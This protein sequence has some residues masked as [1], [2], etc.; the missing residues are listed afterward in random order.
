MAERCVTE[1]GVHE[2]EPRYH[3]RF[4]PVIVNNI[5]GEYTDPLEWADEIKAV[6]EIRE[7]VYD[8]CTQCGT[9]TFPPQA[10]IE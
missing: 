9:T 10:P 4:D 8:V 6:A 3:S 1:S 2:F 5:V 7:Y